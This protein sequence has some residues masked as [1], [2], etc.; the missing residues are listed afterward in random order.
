MFDYSG[1]LDELRCHTSE[2]LEARRVELVAEQR[3]LRVE[4]LAV[5]AVLDE[6]GAVS[7][8]TAAGDGVSVRVWRDT[9][10]TARALEALPSLADAAHAGV[11]SPEQLVPAAR[12]A[13][14]DS[15]AEWAARAAHTAASDLQKMVRTQRTPTEEEARERRRRRA[16]HTFWDDHTGMFR[17]AGAGL[18][19]VDGALVESVLTHMVDRMKPAKGQPWESRAARTA[20]ALVEL[21]RNYADVHAVGHPAPLFVVHIGEDGPAEICGIPLPEGMVEQLRA[22]AKIKAVLVDE[23]GVEVARGKAT[24]SLPPR[25]RQSVL[26]RDGH[27][28]LGDCSRRHGLQVHHLWPKSWGGGDDQ[29]NLAVACVGGGTD[30]HADLAPHGPWLLLGNPNRPDGLASGAPSAVAGTRAPRRPRRRPLVVRAFDH[31]RSR[32]ARRRARPHPRRTRHRRRLTHAQRA[33]SDF[34][35]GSLTTRQRTGGAFESERMPTRPPCWG[36]ASKWR[37]FRKGQ[38]S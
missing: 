23:H 38:A 19:D 10:E 15:D 9:V 28:R 6:R 30:H 24:P 34:P 36:G 17:F 14:E 7:D 32:A 33:R 21:A 13:D 12:L 3:R 11:V 35:T 18:P 26:R 31:L 25:V 5:V 37:E 16:V 1:R 22:S 4:E 8:A 29:S 20:D 27:C 2:W